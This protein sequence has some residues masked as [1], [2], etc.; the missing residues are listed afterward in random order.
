MQSGQALTL[1]S[2]EHIL[3]IAVGEEPSSHGD[4]TLIS[5][6]I[7]RSWPAGIEPSCCLLWRW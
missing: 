5:L 6:A 1:P 3:V 4:V 7:L 2:F